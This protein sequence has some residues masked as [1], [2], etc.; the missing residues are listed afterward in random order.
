[1][2][3]TELWAIPV[4]RPTAVMFWLQWRLLCC[5][6]WP[7]RQLD[8]IPPQPSDGK[9]SVGTGSLVDIADAGLRSTAAAVD[10]DYTVADFCCSGPGYYNYLLAPPSWLAGIDCL[11][12]EDE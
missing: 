1:M 9:C 11:Q 7:H 6:S 5:T 10:I 8:L 3:T 2:T 4:K 12:G